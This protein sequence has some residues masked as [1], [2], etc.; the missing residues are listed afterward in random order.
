MYTNKAK[1]GNKYNSKS[2]E[3]EKRCDK[4]RRFFIGGSHNANN[5]GKWKME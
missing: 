3:Q 5:M 4:E 2:L 1:I